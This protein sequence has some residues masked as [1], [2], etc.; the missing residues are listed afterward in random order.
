MDAAGPWVPVPILL[1]MAEP[2]GPV[3]HAFF[4]RLMAEWTERL[5]AALPVDGVYCV[6]HGAGLT[7]EDDDPEGTLLA[8]IREIV[9][10]DIPVVGS[11]DLHANVSDAMVETPDAF[12]GY[13]TNP[14]M[15]MRECGAESA[16]VMRRLLGGTRT[17]VARARLPIVPPTVTM[18]TG[19]EVPDR[20]YG[21]LIDLGQR[22]MA[23]P[24]YAGRVL[25]VSVMGG[26]AF[27]DTAFNGLT[28]VVTATDR[29]TAEALALDLAKAGWQRRHRFWWESSTTRTSRPKRI[30]AARARASSR[31]SITTPARISPNRFRRARRCG[32][33][34]PA[35]SPAAAASSPAARS[36]SAPPPPSISTASSSWW[37][38]AACNAP[39]PPSSRHSAS[40]SPAP[41]WWWSNRAGISAAASTSSSATTRSWKSTPPA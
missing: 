6:L 5:R 23:A 13:R 21:E 26:F 16:Q 10:P 32:A 36:T 7:T 25:N 34:I 15:D 41:A 8:A 35:P 39:I 9:G 27:A 33:C 24:P 2:N 3:D 22:L 17:H 38:R 40:T 19:A 37:S 14:H 11:F 12:I 1:A 31:I 30:A 20:P 28:A 4:A 29:A 18:L